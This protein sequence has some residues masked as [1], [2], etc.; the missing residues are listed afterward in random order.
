MKQLIL[1]IFETEMFFI[2]TKLVRSQLRRLLAFVLAE[3]QGIPAYQ[4]NQ[5]MMALRWGW[6]PNFLIE[7]GIFFVC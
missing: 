5:T 1:F 6:N 3:T 4:V 7:T 2:E